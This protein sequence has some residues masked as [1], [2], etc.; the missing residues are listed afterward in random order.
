MCW[1]NWTFFP[2]L[3][4]SF[5]IL[6]LAKFSVRDLKQNPR[7]LFCSSSLPRAS[8]GWVW[9]LLLTFHC[10]LYE[11]CAVDELGNIGKN[12]RSSD[13]NPEPLACRSA[14]SN[15]TSMLCAP[16]TSFNNELK[17]MFMLTNMRLCPTWFLT[18]VESFYV[19]I[20]HRKTCSEVSDNVF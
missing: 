15:A 5:K 3:A 19:A 1:P 7:I 11:Q 14:S 4:W 16:F 9:S 8:T 6:S 13:W 10:L 12:P 2:S 17:L 18:L 20:V